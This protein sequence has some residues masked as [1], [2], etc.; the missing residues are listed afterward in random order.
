MVSGR[1]VRITAALAAVG[2][3]V[4][5]F[6]FAHGWEWVAGADDRALRV[7]YGFGVHRPA[8]IEFWNAVSALLGPTVLR[9]LAAVGIAVALV[10]RRPRTAVF[11]ALTVMAMGL[12]TVAAKALVDRPRPS[13]ALTAAASSSFPS[14][15]ALGIMVGVL[16]FLTVL[17]PVLPAGA[18][19]WAVAAGAGAVLLVGAARVVL[20][21]HHPSDVLAGWALGYLWFLACVTV[22][23]PDLRRREP[24]PATR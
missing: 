10:R 12:V 2:Y 15:H 20:N 4:L 16:A 5:W 21:V 3:A 14:G 7:T 22:A 8:W 6:G 17:V 1:V 11:L 19:V 23:P 18:R 24:G 13:T 9:V